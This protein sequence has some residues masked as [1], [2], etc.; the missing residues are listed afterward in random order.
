MR[1]KLGDTL[2]AMEFPANNLAKLK[3]EE[4]T[5]KKNIFKMKIF[6]LLKFLRMNNV[7]VKYEA[8]FVKTF[9]WKIIDSHI[10]A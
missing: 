10:I 1:G 4:C 8:E 7:F 2:N 6:L 9:L 3:R 5:Y